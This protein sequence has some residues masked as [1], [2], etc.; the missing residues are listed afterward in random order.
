MNIKNNTIPQKKKGYSGVSVWTQHTHTIEQTQYGIPG[1]T[2]KEGRALGVFLPDKTALFSLYIPNGGKSE[3]AFQ[4]KLNFIKA[5]TSYTKKL[6]TQGYN[7]ILGGDFNIAHNAIDLSQPEKHEGGTHFSKNLTT[8]FDSFL[9]EGLI[10]TFRE[11][12]PHKKEMYSYWDNFDFSLPRGTKPREV[13]RGWR[14]DYI[15]ATH[16]LYKKSIQAT[17]HTNTHGSDHCPIVFEWK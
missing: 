12:H 10:D 8:I 3:E 14:I 15:C 13:N 4:H 2:D 9:K 1:F 11:T 5:L 6:I 16:T 7:I 17:I